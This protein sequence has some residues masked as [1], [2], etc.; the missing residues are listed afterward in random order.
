MWPYFRCR[1]LSDSSHF[2]GSTPA[3]PPGPASPSHSSLLTAHLSQ[4]PH[5]VDQKTRVMKSGAPLLRVKG[6][7]QVLLRPSPS[8]PSLPPALSAPHPGFF[9]VLQTHQGLLLLLFPDARLTSVF[10]PW[11]ASLFAMRLSLLVVLLLTPPK[12]KT[13]GG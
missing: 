3:S 10:T 5:M 6:S 11:Q 12:W 4:Q 7:H 2:S 13:R 8:P 1:D 9:P